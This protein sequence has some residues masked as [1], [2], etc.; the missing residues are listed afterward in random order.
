LEKSKL[1]PIEKEGR[2]EERAAPSNVTLLE[3]HD[4]H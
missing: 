1:K 4:M 3:P 2:E